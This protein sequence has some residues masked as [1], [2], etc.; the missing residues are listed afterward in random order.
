M[1]IV[2]YTLAPLVVI[3]YA[4]LSVA[5][6]VTQWTGWHLYDILWVNAV[7]LLIGYITYRAGSIRAL[8]SEDGLEVHNVFSTR[9]FE[10][11]QIL[12]ASL[13]LTSPWVVMD[14]SDGTTHSV[15]AIQHSDG[16]HA[17]K[18]VTRLR[19]LIETQTKGSP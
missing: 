17:R 11:N 15:M 2:C 19:T 8:P 1:R 14:L 3:A 10:W 16:D 18:A 9:F 12:T 6:T 7:G 5:L 13:P 4:A